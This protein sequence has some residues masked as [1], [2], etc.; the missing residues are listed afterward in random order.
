[1]RH[2][3]PGACRSHARRIGA[4]DPPGDFPMLLTKHEGETFQNQTVYISGQ[5][6]INCTFTACTLI[7]RGT[8]YHLQN[9]TFERCNWH[10]DWVLMW[11]SVESVREIKALVNLIEQAQI[12]QQ[13]Q[14]EQQGG[15]QGVEAAQTDATAGEGPTGPKSPFA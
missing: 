12:Q 4:S 1:M 2:P 11:G 14:D 8:V 15:T 10:V 5:A 6:F 13:L 9:C 7:L 3:A